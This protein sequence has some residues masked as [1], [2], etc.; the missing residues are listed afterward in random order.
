MEYVLGHIRKERLILQRKSIQVPLVEPESIP[1]GAF[2]DDL[3]LNIAFLIR[4]SS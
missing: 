1:N 3:K 4:W 2:R